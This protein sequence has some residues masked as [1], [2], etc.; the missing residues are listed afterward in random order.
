MRCIFGI[1]T[2]WHYKG[3]TCWGRIQ[4]YGKVGICLG[5]I[6]Y[7]TK[8]GNMLREDPKVTAKWGHVWD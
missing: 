8:M 1:D 7:G 4:S 2:V 6:Q 3:V 5:F